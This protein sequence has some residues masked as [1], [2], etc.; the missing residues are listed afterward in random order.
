[1][2]PCN[3]DTS[4]SPVSPGLPSDPIIL[5]NYTAHNALPLTLTQLTELVQPIPKA[6]ITEPEPGE[7][8]HYEHNAGH[9]RVFLD[10]WESRKPEQ[11]CLLTARRLRCM[12][13]KQT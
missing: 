3:R 8:A 6:P 7:G 2:T 5:P 11:R 12:L 4:S 9:N 10:T 1:M 13:G